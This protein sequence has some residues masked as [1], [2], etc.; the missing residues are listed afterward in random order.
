MSKNLDETVR[1]QARVDT[2]DK[3]ERGYKGLRR[4]QVSKE[5]EQSRLSKVPDHEGG[6]RGESEREHG[7]ESVDSTVKKG[8]FQG[9]KREQARKAFL[10]EVEGSMSG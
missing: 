9:G 8:R 6:E 10:E 2:R 4:A 3:E 7:E 1:L 5:K